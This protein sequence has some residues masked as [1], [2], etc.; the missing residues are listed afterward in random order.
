[1]ETPIRFKEF[2]FDTDSGELLRR[3]AAGE[4][5]IR[6]AP[7][8][9]K[10]LLLLL[11]KYPAVVSQEEIRETI[12]PE[13][14]VDFERSL[15]YCIRQIRAALEDDATA[16]SYIET[17][18]RRGY[19]WIAPPES[20][21]LPSPSAPA[22]RSPTRIAYGILATGLLLLSVLL[23]YY[24]PGK[25]DAAGTIAAA[26]LRVA[27][28]SFQP[29][30][31]IHGFKGNDIALQLV[32]LL[33]NE[34]ALR[35]EVIGPSTTANYPREQFR[36]MLLELQIDCVLNGRF[37][38]VRDTSRLLAEVIRVNDGA[39]VWVNYFGDDTPADSIVRA[40]H[41]G[42]LSKFLPVAV[43]QEL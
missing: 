23:W 17:I 36:Q 37:S 3:N 13:V 34:Q 12:W 28:M 9:A 27:V 14:Q 22:G 4:H 7:Q 40:I 25:T 41:E 43:E 42:M 19:R 29:P 5:S 20:A 35:M 31:T 38:Q 6:L 2:L 15:H 33:T 39:H 8:P 11:E 26:P 16:P 24:L 10:L 21:A 18:P 1:M 32:D 30:D